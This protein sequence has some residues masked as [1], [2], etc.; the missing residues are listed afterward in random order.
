MSDEFDFKE[1][2][3]K[4]L[5]FPDTVFSR[6]IES[7]VFQ[8]ITVKCL[9]TIDGVQLLEGN[10]FGTL[11]GREGHEKVKGIHVEQDQKNHSVSLKIELNVAYGLAIPEKAEE[12]QTK[13]TDEICNLTGLHVG[14][15]HIVFKNLISEIVVDKVLPQLE[16]KERAEAEEEDSANETSVFEDCYF[17]RI[18]L[19]LKI[20]ERKNFILLF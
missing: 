12:I 10:L 20:L 6:D 5:N 13:I 2:D 9:T 16:Q 14:C 7:R 1:I 3:T 19:F 15:V 11:L 8:A 4:E 17:F 18:F